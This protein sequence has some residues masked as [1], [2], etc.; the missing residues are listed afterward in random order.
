MTSTGASTTTL[1]GS[2]LAIDDGSCQAN[3]TYGKIIQVTLNSN[4]YD[5]AMGLAIIDSD[6]ELSTATPTQ[7]LDVRA[8]YPKYAQKQAVYSDLTFTSSDTAKATV[9]ANGL[10]TKVATGNC[11]ITAKVTSKPTL[12]AIANVTVS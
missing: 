7:K 12:E 6:V 5:E 10:V 4:W 3:K 1:N 11:I 9:D 2:A 8:V